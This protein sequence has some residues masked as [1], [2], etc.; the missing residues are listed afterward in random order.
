M[1]YVCV[2]GVLRHILIV[3]YISLQASLVTIY[4]AVTICSDIPGISTK[5]GFCT[6]V[7]V[8]GRSAGGTGG[9]T[10]LMG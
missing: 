4:N 7:V 1:G 9:G 6:C 3:K 5:D 2:R 8:E 10:F